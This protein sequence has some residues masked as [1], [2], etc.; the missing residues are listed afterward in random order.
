LILQ[1]RAP[2]SSG[3]FFVFGLRQFAA[4]SLKILAHKLFFKH[5]RRYTRAHQR[6]GQIHPLLSAARSIKGRSI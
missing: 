5:F 4:F 3:A 1:K 2:A 6:P